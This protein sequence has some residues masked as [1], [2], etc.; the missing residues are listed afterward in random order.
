MQPA[1]RVAD[2]LVGVVLLDG[3]P[4]SSGCGCRSRSRARLAC[5]PRAAGAVGMDHRRDGYRRGYGRD[6]GF[7]DP[8]GL[9]EAAS[10]CTPRRGVGAWRPAVTRASRRVTP[11]PWRWSPCSPQPGSARGGP[12]AAHRASTGG[13]RGGRVSAPPAPP[14]G[15]R[16]GP[17]D[18]FFLDGDDGP[19]PTTTRTVDVADARALTDALEDGPR[20]HHPRL[21]RRHLR[22]RT[23]P[24]AG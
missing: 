20:R 10:N 18:D 21:G 17:L 19:V 11:S 22:R 7:T 8:D 4:A 3:R 2:R 23:S 16:P 15:S 9:E 12:G 5:A 6:P 14:A 1:D 24:C 13:A